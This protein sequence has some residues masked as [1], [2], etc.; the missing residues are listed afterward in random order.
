MEFIPA[1]YFCACCT[2]AVQ[3]QKIAA[4]TDTDLLKKTAVPW[5]FYYRYLF[6]FTFLLTN[7]N[8]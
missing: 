4:P 3:K 1:L 8:H 6:Y 2:P 5:V 7:T